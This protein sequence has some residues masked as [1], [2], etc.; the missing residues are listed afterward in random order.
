[1]SD[2]VWKNL[3][4]IA[5]VHEKELSAGKPP[6]LQLHFYR[7]NSSTPEKKCEYAIKGTFLDKI[8]DDLLEKV[9][10]LSDGDEVCVH[11]GK[12]DKGY[13]M[14]IDISDAKDAEDSKK[15]NGKAQYRGNGQP[16]D[17][18]GVAVGAAWT[19]AVEILTASGLLTDLT[20]EDAI[21]TVHKASEII[22]KV[23]LDQENK[24]RAAKKAKT[25]VADEA[26]TKALSKAEE[27][28]KRAEAKKA[29]AKKAKSEPVP[30][31]SSDGIE[32]P[33]LE[34]DDLDSV[35]WGE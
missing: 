25:E 23:K 7:V 35:N 27:I 5:C 21:D 4:K 9:Y 33:D 10:S 11:V 29:A 3:G 28:K 32:E 1:M 24:L 14:V 12:D 17:T 34:D 2:K 30:E 19:N 26:A 8:A 22:L 18:S 15:S 31:S 6:I 13:P 20:L 16:K